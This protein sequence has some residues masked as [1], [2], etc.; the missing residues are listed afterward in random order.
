MHPARQPAIQS[1]AERMGIEEGFSSLQINGQAKNRTR[2]DISVN[3]K[4]V[5]AA[6]RLRMSPCRIA[7]EAARPAPAKVRATALGS[8]NSLIIINAFE[9]HSLCMRALAKSLRPTPIKPVFKNQAKQAIT[10]IG[11]KINKAVTNKGFVFVRVVM[12]Q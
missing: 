7:A 3:P 11:P 8:R 12:N 1:A 2:L 9:S 6:K 10:K 4:A 5:G